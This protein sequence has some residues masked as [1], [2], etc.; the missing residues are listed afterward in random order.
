MAK[1]KSTAPKDES[2]KDKFR[3]I[4][5]PR[6]GKAIKFIGLIGNCAGS[7]YEYGTT[8]VARIMVALQDAVTQLEEQFTS[9]GAKQSGFKLE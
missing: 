2:K 7:E 3:R 5:E 6:V 9:K 8:D 4:V 1:R